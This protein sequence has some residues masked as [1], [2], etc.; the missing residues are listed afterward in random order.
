MAPVTE[1]KHHRA[2]PGRP[3]V[4]ALDAA[5]LRATLEIVGEVGYE[6]LSIEAVARRAG[7]TKPSLYRRWPGKEALV[8]A[9]LRSYVATALGPRESAGTGHQS[10]L[11][12]ELL[13]RARTLATAMTPDHLAVFAGVLLAIRSNQ[14]LAALVRQALVETESRAMA[15]VLARAAARGEIPAAQ[16]S[17][18]ALHVLPAVLFLRL[19]VLD[20]PADEAF[21]T[22]LVDEVLMPLFTKGRPTALRRARRDSLH[23]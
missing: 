9:A 2:A 5:I 7:T 4:K 10:G 13:A 11:R 22:Q 6:G 20:Q 3:P 1:K 12:A 19:L 18:T 8:L 16:V 15:A 23:R 14:A 17:P 21:L